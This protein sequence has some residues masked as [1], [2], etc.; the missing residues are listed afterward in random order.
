MWLLLALLLWAP[1]DGQVDS[2]KAVVTLQPPWVSVFQKESV[3][4]WCDGPRLPGENVTHWFLND[5]VIQTLMPRYS[6]TAASFN[7][8]GEYR[9]RTGL[10]VPSDPVQL[11][12]HSDW[13]LL[14]A[15]S[16]VLTEGEPLTFRCHGWK[17]KL[18]YNV[19]FYQN[20]TSF[21]FLPRNSE[22]TI[23][24]TNL[25]H[26]GIYRC[27]GTGKHR[28]TSAGVAVTVKELFPAPVLRV[29][30]P[31]PLP[32][33][34][35]VTLSCETE[36]LPQRPGLQLHFSFYMNNKALRGRNTSPEYRILNARTKDSGSY[37]C[38]AATEDGSVAKRSSVLELQVADPWSSISVWFHI[39]FYLSVGI[40][41]LVNT[42]L[43]M[44]IHKQVQKK[45]R[46]NLEIPLASDHEKKVTP[47][48]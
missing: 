13:L 31:S 43:C 42:V 38:E 11:E 23:L 36:L 25:S 37:W 14:Q 17:N 47:M 1:V 46:W 19:V 7:D 2:I 8:S 9:C 30:L 21:K 48:T 22:L 15:S 32:E 5:T 12:I 10:S 33:G 26:N 35:L 28:Y 27:S 4:L 45:K 24:Q 16:R 29:S 20:G 40:I 6:I 39:L 3:T 44:K 34:S 41:F 18:V